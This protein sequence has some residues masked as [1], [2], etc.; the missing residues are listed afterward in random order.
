MGG[1]VVSIVLAVTIRAQSNETD[2][3][4]SFF[5]DYERNTVYSVTAELHEERGRAARKN[6]HVSTHRSRA[7]AS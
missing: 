3:G 1:L 4:V 6:F 5:P 7:T 2:F